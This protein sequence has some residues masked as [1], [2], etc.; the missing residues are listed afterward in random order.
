MP[1]YMRCSWIEI[2]HG[3]HIEVEN[4]TSFVVV[5]ISVTVC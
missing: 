5:F 3:V 2:C 4:E 1:G